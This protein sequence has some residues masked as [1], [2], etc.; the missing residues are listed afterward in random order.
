MC[1]YVFWSECC[2]NHMFYTFSGQNAAKT[3]C[4]IRVPIRM[5]QNH[6]FYTFSDQNAAKTICF[7]RV[8]VRM[9]QKSHMFS[10]QSG[11]APGRRRAPPGGGP[12]R[13]SLGFLAIFLGFSCDFPLEPALA[14]RW[15]PRGPPPALG[16]TGA[17]QR[18]PSACIE[19]VRKSYGNRT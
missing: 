16:Q 6:M 8:L 17:Q 19:I 13:F 15:R 3:I 10:G 9:P 2:N 14:P 18:P 5:S 12:A 7:I 1:L 4:F 11:A